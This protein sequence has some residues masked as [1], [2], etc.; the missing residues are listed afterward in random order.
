MKSFVEKFIGEKVYLE[1]GDKVKL[2]VKM[3]CRH[4]LGTG[5]TGG[6]MSAINW[7]E[8]KAKITGGSNG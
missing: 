7:E 2:P 3:E 6:G 5:A 4:M 8:E 1:L